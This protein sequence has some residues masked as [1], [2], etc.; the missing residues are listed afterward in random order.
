[1]KPL[2]PLIGLVLILVSCQKENS[3]KTIKADF[4]ISDTLLKVYENPGVTNLSDTGAIVY[5][6][7]FGDGFISGEKNPVHIYTAPG[8]Y[9]IKLKITDNEGNS[10][11]SEQHIKVG[12][13][14]VY[15]IVISS[16]AE[17]KWYPDFGNWDADSTGINSY[18]DVYFVIKENNEPTLFESKSIYNV[19]AIQL[20]LKFSIPDIK[21]NP[22]ASIGIGSTGIYLNDRDGTVSE[23]IASNLMSG[24]QVYDDTY[25]KITHSGEFSVSFYSSYTVK[26]RIK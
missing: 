25:D 8:S 9:V 19:N 2:F 15:E 17:Q 24:A 6:W 20:P 11:S 22:N 10:D 13:R 7:D 23:E 4:S 1:M 16:L 18:P 14:F 21:I 12:E 26:Y 5:N 3:I